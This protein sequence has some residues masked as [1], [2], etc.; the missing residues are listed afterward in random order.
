MKTEIIQKTFIRV[1][2]VPKENITEGLH[3]QFN[4]GTKVEADVAYVDIIK[5]QNEYEVPCN[6]NGRKVIK[7]WI[8]Q[9]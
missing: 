3:I 8:K 4:R 2:P 5:W 7:S 1:C 6:I 9:T